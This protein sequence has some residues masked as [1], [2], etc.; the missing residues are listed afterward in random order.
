MLCNEILTCVVSVPEKLLEVIKDIL[1][2]K[3][4]NCIIVLHSLHSVENIN[5]KDFLCS[6]VCSGCYSSFCCV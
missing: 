6:F 2:K 1:K 3:R 4:L 5:Q